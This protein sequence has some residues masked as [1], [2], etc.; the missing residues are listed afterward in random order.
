MQLSDRPAHTPNTPGKPT[1]AGYRADLQAEP[2]WRPL[3]QLARICGAHTE[4]PSVAPGDFMYMGRLV[5]P[6]QPTVVMYKHSGTRRHL[7]LDDLGHAYTVKATGPRRAPIGSL[8]CQPLPDLASALA[9]VYDPRLARFATAG[10]PSHPSGPPTVESRP[11]S[12]PP[13]A[14]PGLATHQGL[15]L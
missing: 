2:D 12:P 4:L 6:Q 3:E 14:P 8:T 13:P 15:G 5:H 9:Q 10:T 1:S 7:C 11:G